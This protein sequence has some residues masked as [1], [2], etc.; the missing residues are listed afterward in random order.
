MKKLVFLTLISLVMPVL[1]AAEAAAIKA[2]QALETGV[3]V[4]EGQR[5]AGLT[6][7][8]TQEL[9]TNQNP[10]EIQRLL[11]EGAEPHGHHLAAAVGMSPYA[12]YTD[13]HENTP[14]IVNQL[15]AKNKTI[16]TPG[17]LHGT[18]LSTDPA[19]LTTFAILLENGGFD[20]VKN[21]PAF[22]A[23][24]TRVAN[25][26]KNTDRSHLSVDQINTLTEKL[27]FYKGMLERETA[28][29]PS[30]WS[31][32]TG[33]RTDKPSPETLKIAAA[34]E[35]VNQMRTKTMAALP[36]ATRVALLNVMGSEFRPAEGAQKV[37]EFI[38]SNFLLRDL[39]QYPEFRET[40]NE[41]FARAY[42]ITPEEADFYLFPSPVKA[43]AQLHKLLISGQDPET[44]QLLL[45]RG[46]KPTAEH[47][48]TAIQ[49]MNRN[50]PAII[51]KL[52]QSGVKIEDAP[53]AVALALNSTDPLS[54]KIFDTLLTKSDPKKIAKNPLLQQIIHLISEDIKN[55]P[56]G[57]PLRATPL[58]ED[59][60]ATLTKKFY[61]YNSRTGANMMNV[62]KAKK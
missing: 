15:L 27:D 24:L 25:M 58:T 8:L 18:L 55:H 5:I 17:A 41:S 61:N 19:S 62:F 26:I 7:Q 56:Y 60:Y 32:L 1:H 49:L 44:L 42:N 30:L 43:N 34:E 14:L 45:D 13:I 6:N 3:S 46:A 33:T 16:I 51:E 20:L 10:A 29:R 48:I 4:A 50:T 47:L 28:N 57:S 23:D 2:A 22:T 12:T 39:S 53:Q 11:E 59:E 52:I 9:Y 35:A 37:N 54:I 38:Q 31:R 21:D 40:L 36:T